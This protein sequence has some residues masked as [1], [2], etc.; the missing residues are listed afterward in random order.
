M[1]KFLLIAAIAVC[2][3][4]SANAQETSFGVKAGV[5]LAN[6]NTDGDIDGKTSFYLG[7]VAEFGLSESFALQPELVYSMQGA[8]E[9]DL[10]YINIPVLAK[11]YLV[12]G[13]AV[14]VGPQ[15]G[16]VVDDEDTEAESIDFS[17]AIGAEYALDMGVF[18]Q[19]RYNLGLTDVYDGI[20][21]KNSVFQIGLGYK[22]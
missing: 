9:L 20:D 11:Y 21:S 5:N 4:F 13:L 14:E 8:D 16:F 15:F 1:K 18:F 17:A 2:G 12:E 3:M 22:F 7:A 6:L 10:S 19:A